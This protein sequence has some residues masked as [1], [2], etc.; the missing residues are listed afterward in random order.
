MAIPLLILL[1]LL[2]VITGIAYF[3][4]QDA[5]EA[6]LKPFLQWLFAPRQSFWKRVLLWPVK[7]IGK[8][9]AAVVRYVKRVLGGAAFLAASAVAHFLMALAWVIELRALVALR[10]AQAVF[11][12]LVYLRNV[13]IPTLVELVV[14][15][16]RVD[17]AT[18]KALALGVASTLTA[19]SVEIAKGIAFLPG[20]TPLGLPARVAAW[21]DGFR[22][23][24]DKVFKDLAPKLTKAITVTIPKLAGEVDDIF[25]DLYKTGAKSL[26]GIRS[27]LADLEKA[28]VPI[29]SNPLAWL[30][31]L[32]GSVA[33]IAMLTTVLAKVAPQLFCRNTTNAAKALCA[34]SFGGF[35]DVLALLTQAAIIANF[36]TYVRIA[37]GATEATADGISTLLDVTS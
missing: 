15:P 24:W 7:E 32:L 5:V 35:D 22:V 37:Q 9:L 23:L 30:A 13:A 29:L 12:G 10:L 6:W 34:S 14:K 20:V 18:A 17:A 26:P 4:L 8:G 2:V 27:R 16:V 3:A 11:N 19:V 21:L 1:P 31:A 25:T 28:L 36:E 33:G